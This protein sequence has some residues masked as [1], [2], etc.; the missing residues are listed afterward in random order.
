MA[1]TTIQVS[2]DVVARLRQLR[3]EEEAP[4]YDAVLRGLLRKVAVPKESLWGLAAGVHK[5][6]AG[7][8]KGLRD[9]HE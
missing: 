2:E 1:T 7:V 3:E 5:S 6:F 8:M 9:E 4:S